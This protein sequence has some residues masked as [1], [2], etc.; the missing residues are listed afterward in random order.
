MTYRQAFDRLGNQV[1]PPK[2]D[3][4]HRLIQGAAWATAVVC[5]LI[6]IWRR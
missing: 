6:L 4:Q 3:W 2:P 1:T 5:L